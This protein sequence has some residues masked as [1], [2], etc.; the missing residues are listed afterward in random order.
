MYILTVFCFCLQL[1]R[2]LHLWENLPKSKQ[3]AKPL[4][5]ELE[6]MLLHMRI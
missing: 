4:I 3:I 5:L 6:D 2:P 1:L